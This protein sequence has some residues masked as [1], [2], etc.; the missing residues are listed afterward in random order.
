MTDIRVT[1]RAGTMRHVAGITLLMT[2]LVLTGCSD[3]R[4][5]GPAGSALRTYAIDLTGGARVC[6]VP[7]VAPAAGGNSEV[8][9]QVAND[10]GWCG[11]PV[12]QDGPKP[13][14]AGLLITRAAHG[15]VTI[16]EVGDDTRIDYTP[17]RGFAGKD[18]FVVKLIPGNATVHVAVTVTSP[19]APKG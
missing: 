7:K 11:I 16:H 3:N 18:A 4:T 9:I 19:G 14:G 17:D 12:H 15:S 2:G 5:A 13:F 1:A 8:A 10:G 6:E